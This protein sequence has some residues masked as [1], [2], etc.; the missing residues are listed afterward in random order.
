MNK[1]LYCLGLCILSICA[2]AQ[3]YKVIAQP[4]VCMIQTDEVQSVVAEPS[5][6][7][8]SDD[9]LIVQSGFI[10]LNPEEI[11]PTSLQKIKADDTS[12]NE[13]IFNI[14]GQKLEKPQRG[15]NIINKRKVI[16]K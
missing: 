8:S 12:Q 3:D 11:V 13:Q 14:T 6:A 1:F 7:I 15:I 9:N 16:L 5:V 2:D 4:V 10:W